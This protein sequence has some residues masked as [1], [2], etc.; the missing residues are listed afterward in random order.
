MR[1]NIRIGS[2]DEVVELSERIP[3]FQ[4]PHQKE[5]YVRR[6]AGESLT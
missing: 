6:V 2:I 5:E 4:R 1:V 3:E